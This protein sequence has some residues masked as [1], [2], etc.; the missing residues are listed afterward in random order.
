MINFFSPEGYESVAVDLLLEQGFKLEILDDHQ[1]MAKWYD[2]IKGVIKA[3]ETH[4]TDSFGLPWISYHFKQV[5]G[6]QFKYIS[7][8]LC[9]TEDLFSTGDMIPTII[10]NKVIHI[11]M[12]KASP[13]SIF[14]KSIQEIQDREFD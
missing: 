6:M 11:S 10:K 3:K 14:G 5:P 2:S 13:L 8:R 7:V 12:K 9:T 4:W 1:A